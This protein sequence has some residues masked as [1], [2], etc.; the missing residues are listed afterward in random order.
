MDLKVGTD[1]RLNGEHCTQ[2]GAWDG[3][4]QL[5]KDRQLKDNAYGRRPIPG[6][7]SDGVVHLLCL[8]LLSCYHLISHPSITI[9]FTLLHLTDVNQL[10]FTCSLSPVLICSISHHFVPPISFPK[11]HRPNVKNQVRYDFWIPSLLV[12]INIH[13]ILTC[14]RD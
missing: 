10:H 1:Q 7:I 6:E 4:H 5:T 2:H 12:Y 8:C 3:E 14:T 13:S 9:P 11:I